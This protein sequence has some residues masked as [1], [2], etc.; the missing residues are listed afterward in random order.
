MKSPIR[1]LLIFAAAA[2]VVAVPA[3][4]QRKTAADEGKRARGLFVNKKADAMSVLV[5]KLEEGQLVPVD[6]GHVFKKGD[7]IKIEF[8]S[9]FEGIIYVVNISPT[10]QRCLL[11]PYPGAQNNTVQADQRYTIPAAGDM[12]QF[13]KERGTEVIQ[14]IMTKDRIPTLDAVIKPQPDNCLSQNAASAAEELQGG[15]TK[16]NVKPAVPDDTKVRSRD[17]ILAPGK[18]KE[19]EGSVVAIPDKGGAGGRLKPGEI[20]PFE[21][22]LKHN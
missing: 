20:A 10:G 22:R 11:F 16:E 6:P 9:N 8:Q 18:S 2:G 12:I 7:Q 3:V 19:K 21:I 15:I 4:A 17:I 14:V 13:D 5:L 1:N